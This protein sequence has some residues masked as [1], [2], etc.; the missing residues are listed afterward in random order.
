MQIEILKLKANVSR[1]QVGTTLVWLGVLVWAPFIVLRV[2]GYKP[3]VYY[4]L[5]IHLLGVIGGSRLRA[6][7][8]RKTDHGKITRPYS[9]KIAHSLILLGVMAWLPYFTLKYAAGQLVQILPFLTVHLIGVLSGVGLLIVSALIA[10]R[11]EG[12][13]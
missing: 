1:E 5:S 9:Q 8:R 3:P 7:A 6:S 10:R 13:K 12:D 11:Q 4:Y 2:A